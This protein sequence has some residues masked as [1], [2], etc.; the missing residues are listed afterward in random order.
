[1]FKFIAARFGDTLF[2]FRLQNFKISPKSRGRRNSQTVCLNLKFARFFLIGGMVKARVTLL[3]LDRREAS[4]SLAAR[5][6]MW[7]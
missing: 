6:F 1:M 2:K 5:L 3:N 7:F 4:K